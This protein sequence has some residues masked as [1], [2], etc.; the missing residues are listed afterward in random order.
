MDEIRALLNQELFDILVLT[1]TKIDSSYNNSLFQHPLYRIIR[2]DRKKGGGGIMVYIKH[3]VSAYRRKQ[4]E[5]VDI[6]AVCIDVKG[7]ANT[8]FSLLACYRSPN[9]NKPTEFLSS[10]YS[11]TENLYKHRNELLI[12]GDLNFNM[13]KSDD[14]SPDTR[15]SEC[16]DRFQLTNTVTGPTRTTDT[17]ST[18]LDVILTTHPQRFC[19]TKTLQLGISDHDM[20]VT[21][22][23][24]KLPKSPPKLISYRSMKRF[25]ADIFL[26]DLNSVP[27]DSAFI[28]DDIDDIWAHWYKLFT[29]V[30]DRHAPLKR[31]LVRGNTVSWMTPKIIQA[32]NTRNRLHR[33]FTKNKTSENWEA[34]RKQR[35]FVTSLKR[36][37]LKSYCI[38]VS[39]N[40]EHPG[41]F[42]KKFHCLLPSKDRGNSHIQLIEDGRLITDSIDVANLLNDYFIHAVPRPTHMSNLQPEE[43]KTHSSVIAIEQKFKGQMSF[44]FTPVRDSYIKRIL[45]SI[46]INKATG[47]DGISPRLLKLAEPG[48]LSS[49]TKFINRCITG[50]SWPTNWKTSIISPIYKKDSETMKSNYRP[51]SVLSAVSKIAERVIFDQL[52]E[53]SL[54]FLSGNLSG[55]LKGHSCTT[56][57]SSK[58]AKTLE[59]I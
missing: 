13:L 7:R 42:W 34:Y 3:S 36:S 38:N 53:F 58:H 44:S 21:I 4:L 23:K 22:R 31:K 27:W 2:R 46:K 16:C 10:L 17:S 51:V 33:K 15:L 40:S 41:E 37:S 57:A 28:Y 5:P 55:F 35:N 29:E 59:Q 50:S 19:Y 49:L 30:I 25:D 20:V 45:S 12:I 43:F 1:E 18:L 47:A 39:T 48:I 32:I 56:A 52:Y 9:K 6:E 26:Q 8:L 11:T 54:H 24:W 14:C